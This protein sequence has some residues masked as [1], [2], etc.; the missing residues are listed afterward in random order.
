MLRELLP[1]RMKLAKASLNYDFDIGESIENSD[2][3]E[4]RLQDHDIEMAQSIGYIKPIKTLHSI[5]MS[6]SDNVFSHEYI[7]ELFIAEYIVSK[8]LYSLQIILQALEA[9][10]LEENIRRSRILRFICGMSRATKREEALNFL[11]TNR[12]WN[13]LTDCMYESEN[14][15]DIIDMDFN[16]ES[17]KPSTLL[18]K[19]TSHSKMIV[20]RLDERY[21][22]NAF[23]LFMGKCLRSKL[24]FDSISI[25][26]ECPLKFLLSLTL[27]V[28]DTFELCNIS[29][30]NKEISN[31]FV[32]IILWATKTNVNKR[33]RFLKT[34]I[35]AKVDCKDIKGSPLTIAYNADG[36]QTGNDQILDITSGTWMKPTMTAVAKGFEASET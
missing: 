16:A 22:Q 29:Y 5:F 35:P 20:V 19:Y 3:K 14:V 34:N 2:L 27:P 8:D 36:S 33:I 15:E 1:L 18:Q 24:H 23:K 11:L 9:N 25:G 26:A 31:T 21:H 10:K 4:A 6:K 7:Q 32:D 30:V 28:V 17:V 13:T 12:C